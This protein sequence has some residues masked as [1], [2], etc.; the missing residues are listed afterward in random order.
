MF[1]LGTGTERIEEARAT[2]YPETPVIRID[3][4][5]TR[6]KGSMQT[7]IDNVHKGGAQILVGT[8]MLAKGHHFPNVTLVGIVDMDAGLFSIDFRAS[9][10]MAQLLIQ[11]AGR[12]GR[13]RKAGTVLIQTHHPEHPL[14]QTLTHQSYATFANDALIERHEA[15]LPPYHFQALLRVNATSEPAVIQFLHDVKSQ[16]EHLDT[17]HVSVLGPV[18]SPM[19]K[20]AGRFR[21]QLLFQSPERKQRHQFLQILLPLI[22]QMKS[23]RKVRWSI[24]IDPIDLY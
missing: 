20:R 15:M 17:Q 16:I 5:S 2:R 11:V 12:A 7:V 22:G 24:D 21:Y 13:E 14:L 4:D 23:S 19:L 6:R 8:Q 3:R 10:R 18:P 1:P 9:E